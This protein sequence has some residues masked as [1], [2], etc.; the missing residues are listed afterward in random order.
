VPDHKQCECGA[1]LRG[2][3]RP[4]DCKLF[5]TVCTPENPMGSCMVSSEGACA[6]HYAYGGGRFRD[7]P[8]A[9]TPHPHPN[10]LPGEMSKTLH[11]RRDYI[12]PLDFK[13]GRI[14]MNHGAGG[15]ASAQLIEELFARAF[16]NPALRQGNDGALLRRRPPATRLVMATDAHVVSPLFFPAATS[17]ACRCTARSTTWR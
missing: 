1:I 13:H 6:A 14:D 8:G 2:V 11:A 7:I 5:G 12:R 10:P 17:A 3:K 16:D 4:T 15:R 9:P